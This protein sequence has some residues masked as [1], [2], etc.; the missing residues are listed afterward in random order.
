MSAFSRKVLPELLDALPHDDP[1][2]LLSREELHFINHFMGNHSWICRVL[3]EQEM[4]DPRILELGA[5][6]GSLARLALSKGVAQPAQWSALDL[7]PA[8]VDWPVDAVWHQQDLFAGPALPDAEVI[9]ANLFL[10]HFENDQLKK[11]GTRLPESCRL[12]VACEPA[13]R[14]LH[15]LQGHLLSALVDLSP[16][17]HHDMLVSIRAGFLGDE[18]AQALG[19][20]GWQT[21][22][23]M[24]A[25]GAYRFMAWR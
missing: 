16:V 6:D 17:T 14:R 1:A 12:L 25:L 2:A 15:S 23:S 4:C 11:L 7:A 13:R 9:A 21:R 18:L 5:G 22:V 19:L 3:Q 20:Q 24:T 10:H 8:P